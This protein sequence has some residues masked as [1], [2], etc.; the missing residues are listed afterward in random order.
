MWKTF[1]FSLLFLVTSPSYLLA[2]VNQALLLDVL[3][4]NLSH[5]GL[6]V[7]D[8]YLTKDATK[9]S[10][11]DTPDHYTYKRA[12]LPHMNVQADLL[13]NLHVRNGRVTSPTRFNPNVSRDNYLQ[14]TITVRSK[15]GHNTNIPYFTSYGL[16]NIEFI[17]RC[18]IREDC[19]CVL[20][21]VSPTTT[22]NVTMSGEFA[23]FELLVA[24][25]VRDSLSEIRTQIEEVERDTLFN[26]IVSTLDG[27]A[28]AANRVLDILLLQLNDINDTRLST[29]IAS[30]LMNDDE[31]RKALASAVAEIVA[32][33]K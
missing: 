5:I 8:V 15:S 33:R 24:Q 18:A 12:Y 21:G 20:K 30:K 4:K 26:S 19:E 3:T 17:N 13:V 32:Q 25:Y 31:L 2:Q 6:S 1:S 16:D 28:S 22:P 27:N 10:L 11:V 7:C 29:L 9:V 14:Q 23:K